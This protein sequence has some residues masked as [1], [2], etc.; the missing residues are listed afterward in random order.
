ML[1]FT[2]VGHVWG[3]KSF[4]S[5][6]IGGFF[7]LSPALECCF[8]TVAHQCRAAAR[9]HPR[10]HGERHA[11]TAPTKRHFY[12]LLSGSLKVEKSWIQ[13]GCQQGV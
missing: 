8:L 1:L 13:K 9:M 4:C 12:P 11:C 3:T 6:P 5:S 2:E 10:T 7:Q